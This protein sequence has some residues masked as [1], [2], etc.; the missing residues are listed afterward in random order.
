MN[1]DHTKR[2]VSKFVSYN[3]LYNQAR[4]FFVLWLLGH[5]FFLHSELELFVA[6]SQFYGFGSTVEEFTMPLDSS[7]DCP[8]SKNTR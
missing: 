5:E 1:T 7:I 6:V 4:Y 8:V 3:S 2:L